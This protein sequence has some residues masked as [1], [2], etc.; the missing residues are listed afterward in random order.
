MADKLLLAE[1]GRVSM[2]S[3]NQ[4]AGARNTAGSLGIASLDSVNEPTRGF[5]VVEPAKILLHGAKSA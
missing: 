2:P 3:D 5:H 4:A 1:S